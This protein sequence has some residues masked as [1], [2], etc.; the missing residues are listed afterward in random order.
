MKQCKTFGDSTMF[1]HTDDGDTLRH[2][3][4][5]YGTGPGWWQDDDE[6]D[7]VV[8]ERVCGLANEL[9]PQPG[10]RSQSFTEWMLGLLERYRS[11][12]RV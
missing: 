9:P 7:V 11:A 4:S 5:E 3:V 8:R 1:S 10:Q 6:T 12:G 2:M